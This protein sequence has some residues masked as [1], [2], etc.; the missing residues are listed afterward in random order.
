MTA[1]KQNQSETPDVTMKQKIFAK[2]ETE[3][4]STLDVSNPFIKQSPREL[5]SDKLR[6]ARNELEHDCDQILSKIDS[7]LNAN[8][9]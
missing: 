7:L 8:F 6:D 4:D 2:I 3:Q 9:T 1:H 5:K